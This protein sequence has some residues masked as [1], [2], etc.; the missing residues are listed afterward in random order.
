MVTPEV[1][2]FVKVGGLADVVGALPKALARRGHDV[3]VVCPLY[4]SVRVRGDRRV[5]ADPLF[6]HLGEGLEFARV[7]ETTMNGVGVP[8]YF[9]EYQKYYEAREIYEPPGSNEAWNGRRFAFLNRAAVDLCA[10]LRWV[11]DVF[12]CHD[13][14]TGLVPVYLNT[15]LRD[16]PLGPSASV[17]TVHN[18]QFQGYTEKWVLP[19]A[20]VP[21]ETFKH[22]GLESF[23]KVN[24]LKG[25]LYHATKV[26]TVSPTYAREIQGRERG[27]GLDSVLRH[28]SPDLIGILNGIDEE[29]WDPA[30]DPFLPERF[31]PGAMAGKAICK[32]ALQAE[33]GLDPRPEAPLFVAVARLYEQKGL[34][35]LAS[36]VSSFLEEQAAQ[37]AILGAGDGRLENTFQEAAATHRGSMAATIGYDEGRAH[38]LYAGGDFFVMPSR[39]EPCGLSQMYAMRYGNVPVVRATGGLVDTVAPY[40]SGDGAATGFRFEEATGPALRAALDQAAR[41][42]R[43]DPAALEVLRANGMSSRFS[44]D[45]AAQA[46]ENV[47]RWAVAARR[48]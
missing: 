30:T 32:A 10:H 31:G 39:F 25:G 6:V 36:I 2:P 48:G 5:H 24:L 43:E 17:M 20:G 12:H 1:A 9:L 47:Y 40:G 33:L 21:W 27:E 4:G 23:G 19:F 3:R 37:V 15:S 38:R 16:S 41:L 7:V 18:L 11:P 35:L 45:G 22:D 13:W 46:Y 44:W 14:T 8:I 26:T 28:R 29:E 42:F 34:D